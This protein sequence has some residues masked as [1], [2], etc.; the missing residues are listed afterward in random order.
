[1]IT[2]IAHLTIDP[3]Q[4]DAF[5]AAVAAVSC[6][7]RDAPG[8]RGMALEREI[9]DPACYRLRVAWISVDA[10]MVDFRNSEGFQRCRAAVGQVLRG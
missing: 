6:V 3:A 10:H 5:E 9:E 8:C 1:M 7:F 4:A 2:E